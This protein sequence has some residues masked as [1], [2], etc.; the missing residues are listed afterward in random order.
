MALRDRG[1]ADLRVSQDLEDIVHLVDNRAELATELA[2]ASGGVRAYVHQQL[3]DLLAHPLF[4]EALAWTVPYGAD[5][6]YQQILQQ[7]F[8]QLAT[9]AA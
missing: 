6:T 5:Y 7:R 4:T 3:L 9:G 8:Q 1:W 2:Q